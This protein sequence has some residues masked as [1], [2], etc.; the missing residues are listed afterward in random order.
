MKIRSIVLVIASLVVI[1]GC[2]GGS[3]DTPL[4]VTGITT[5]N[6][7]SIEVNAYGIEVCVNQVLVTFQS[8]EDS[9]E[10]INAISQLANGTL[11]GKIPSLTAYQFEVSTT[12]I[13]ELETLIVQIESLPYVV[14]AIENFSQSNSMV[15]WAGEP[16]DQSY[17]DQRES[18]RVEQGTSIY[19]LLSGTDFTPSPVKIGVA[20]VDPVV[21]FGLDD[22]SGY[23]NG[24]NSNHVNVIANG[25]VDLNTDPNKYH[26]SIVMG[27]IAAQIGNGG[28]GGFLASL[29][30]G[31]F[32]VELDG[33]RWFYSMLNAVENLALNGNDIINLSFGTYKSGTQN[34]S[35]GFEISGSDIAIVNASKFEKY[36]SKWCNLINSYPGIT[37]VASAGNSYA[38]INATNMYPAGCGEIADNLIVV[39]GNSSLAGGS[40]Y[41][42]QSTQLASNFGQT[43]DIVA[44]AQIS[45]FPYLFAANEQRSTATGTSFSAPLVSST[46]AAMKSINP[47]LSPSDLKNLLRQSALPVDGL[48]SGTPP[49]T[50]PLSLSE[51][52]AD[53]T[54]LNKSAKLNVAVAI[55]AAVDSLGGTTYLDQGLIAHFPFDGN[56]ND[57]TGNGNN[58]TANGNITY[59]TGVSGTA[60][61]LTAEGDYFSLP[62]AIIGDL[63]QWTVS[64]WVKI[65]DLPFTVNHS[66]PIYCE[67]ASNVWTK[68]YIAFNQNLSNNK[69]SPGY[70]NYSFDF[71]PLPD[72]DFTPNNYVYDLGAWH[73]IAMLR[74]NDSVSVYVDGSFVGTETYEPYTANAPNNF[75]IGY[76][77]LY[78]NHQDYW[79]KGLIDE[80]RFYNRPLSSTEIQSL[81]A[82]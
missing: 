25:G 65:E 12:T 57:I 5:P 60:A 10:N 77:E 40:N 59:A 70:D 28:M 51:V 20:E 27:V 74:D 31:I 78:S 47:A 42:Y 4:I 7:A 73:H 80:L 64:A 2:G 14:D 6:P 63:T 32:T 36:K 54:R 38:E 58:G 41:W 3:S 43:V 35:P 1:S 15:S 24:T 22:F 11:I 68:N 34:I 75:Y 45:T 33:K 71:A 76:R 13:S 23:S 55:Q 17:P 61:N 49:L 82:N 81:S 44:A 26:A 37:F 30:S 16:L 62:N 18:N 52:G 46:L 19:N 79:F 8:G 21:D 9:Q 50:A 69:L 39:G 72:G 29:D 67:S 48:I 56:G 66:H 53:T